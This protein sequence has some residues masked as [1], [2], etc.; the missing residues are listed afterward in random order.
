MGKGLVRKYFLA[1][2][3]HI[4]NPTFSN[5][6]TLHTYPSMEMEQTEFSETS[7]YKIQTPGNNTEESIQHSEHRGSFKSRIDL[8][9]HKSQ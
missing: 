4:N 6:V 1:K 8:S 7:A 9:H 5:L 3:S 2:F